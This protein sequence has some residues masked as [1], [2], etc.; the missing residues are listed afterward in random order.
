MADLGKVTQYGTKTADNPVLPGGWSIAWRPEDL[1]RVAAVA[2][3]AAV[4][5]PSGSTF[6]IWI[7]TTFYGN[8]RNGDIND[9]DPAQPMPVKPGDTVFWHFSTAAGNAPKGTLFLR[10]PPAV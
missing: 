3:H 1:P 10:E 5:G 8:V 4:Q 2:Y 7:D 6:Q 9:W